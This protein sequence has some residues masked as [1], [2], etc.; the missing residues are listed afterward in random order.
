MLWTA[1]LITLSIFGPYVSGNLRLEQFAL[2]PI[3]MVVV[4]MGWPTLMSRPFSPLP[5]LGTWLGLI[6]IIM[7]GT[8]WRP[9]DL[10]AYGSPAVSHG[11]GALL[12]PVMLIVLTWFWAQ[13]ASTLRLITAVA[14][15][16]CAAMTANGLISLIQFATKNSQIISILPQFWSGGAAGGSVASF[17][18]GNGRYT[19][20]FDQPAVSGIAYGVGLLCLLYLVRSEGRPRSILIWPATLLMTAGGL[21]AVSK[22]FVFGALPILALVVAR[23]PQVRLRVAAGAAFVGAAVWALAAEHALPS[24]PSGVAAAKGLVSASS[25]TSQATGGRY[26]SGG[27]LGPVVGDVLHSS[28]VIGFGAG[29][30][31]VA[32]D[33]LWVEI[34]AMGGLAGLVLM[35]TVFVLLWTR[36]T[37]LRAALGTAERSL[38]GAALAL[39]AVVSLGIPSLMT[40]PAAS[41][42]WLI[43][44]LLITGQARRPVR[45]EAMELRESPPQATA[46]AV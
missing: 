20:I 28:P 16:V 19:G 30:L 15:T 12:T 17:S 5:V 43:L 32:Y 38:A 18:G 10:G 39:A 35:V 13:Q 8:L 25:F 42:L 21:V 1:V 36:L 27:T 45:R 7:I 34:M 33:S 41:L 46:A 40:D 2:I 24:W 4:I 29:G 31:N 22:T 14:W 6:G 11:L 3:F 9:A 44:G 26:G 23:T 37:G